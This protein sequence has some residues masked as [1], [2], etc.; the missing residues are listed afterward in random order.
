MQV[1]GN[2]VRFGVQATPNRLS[3][4]EYRDNWLKCERLG[5]DVTYVTDHFV[6]YNPQTGP[7]SVFESTTTLSAMTT[8]TSRMRG[9][10]MV[11]GNTY[12]NPG[13]LA[14]CAVTL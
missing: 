10:I 3:F 1:F 9:G 13:I 5:Y 12:R 4:A 7:T 11:A 14:K 8:L 2:I 6:S